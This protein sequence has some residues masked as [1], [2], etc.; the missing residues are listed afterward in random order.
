MAF[1]AIKLPS[2]SEDVY[3][4][5]FASPENTMTF[6][7]IKNLRPPVGKQTLERKLNRP[8]QRSAFACAN[9]LVFIINENF[10]KEKAMYNT[11]R[12]LIER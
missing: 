7:L 1:G 5:I 11:V 2:C 10:A 3:K 9:N 8:V 12:R 4:S 6:R